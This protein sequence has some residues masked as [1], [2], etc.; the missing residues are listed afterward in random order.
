MNHLNLVATLTFQNGE[1]NFIEE[2][3][4]LAEDAGRVFDDTNFIKYAQ[5]MNA[6]QS[7]PHLPHGVVELFNDAILNEAIDRSM[8]D[9]PGKG[10]P[11]RAKEKKIICI[12]KLTEPITCNICLEDV[13]DNIVKIRLCSHYFC[14]ECIM[15]HF[16]NSAFCPVCRGDLTIELPELEAE[17][18]VD[19][20]IQ[21]LTSFP[22]VSLFQK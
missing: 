17:P 10:E 6:T 20:I 11:L 3:H 14:N 1:G 16:E 19:E 18:T 13:T 15:R 4:D 8:S 9:E 7:E 5:Q 12:D 22:D 2:F 21:S